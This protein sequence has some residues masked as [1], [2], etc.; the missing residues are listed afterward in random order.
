MFPREQRKR[1]TGISLIFSTNEASWTLCS[2]LNLSTVKMI[3]IVTATDHELKVKPKPNEEE[4]ESQGANV[5]NAQQAVVTAGQ[6]INP[7]LPLNTQHH[8]YRPATVLMLG[9]SF[10]R[11]LQE[12][13]TREYGAYDNLGLHYQ[14]A[15]VFW[16]GI[17]GIMV[18]TLRADRLRQFYSIMNE[19]KPDVVFLHIGSNDLTCSRKTPEMVGD[20]ID[21]LC[22]DLMASGVKQLVVSQLAFRKKKGVPR[23]MDLD[24][25]NRRIT[26][27]NYYNKVYH[28]PSSTPECRYWFHKGLWNPQ[29]CTICHDGT[30]FNNRGNKHF[31]RSVRGAVMQAIG[32]ARP[33]LALPQAARP[34]VLEF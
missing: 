12:F 33:Q 17:G 34:V 1:T 13:A 10:V 29:V 21:Q 30:H 26:I 8:L 22:G 32:R 25:Y 27:L 5:I 31:Y 11:R 15:N 28:N 6:V 24:D 9:D 2:S 7:S 19:I 20:S 14:V 16:H 4:E 18:D 23:R 3:G